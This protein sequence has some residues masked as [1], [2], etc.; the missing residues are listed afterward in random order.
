MF[1]GSCHGGARQNGA[2]ENLSS[3][4]GE[5]VASAAVCV[6]AGTLTRHAGAP[7]LRNQSRSFNNERRTLSGTGRTST[8]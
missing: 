8:W 2:L 4:P 6:L 3:Q 1:A 7:C 5:D